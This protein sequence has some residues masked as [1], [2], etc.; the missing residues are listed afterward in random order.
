MPQAF[1]N[2]YRKIARAGEELAR[3]EREIGEFI[4]DDCYK[5]AVE[6]DPQHPGYE[7][8]KAKLIRFMAPCISELATSV[9]VSLR[10]ALDEAIGVV[11]AACGLVDSGSERFLFADSAEGFE[12]SIEAHA[13]QL[14]VEIRA[15]LCGFQPY[16]G[17]NDL[18]FALNVL[19]DAG[20][21]A[22]LAAI[23]TVLLRPYTRFVISGYLGIEIPEH[24]VWNRTEDEMVF[25]RAP[26]D[27][28]LDYEIDFGLYV[29]LD[30]IDPFDIGPL[31]GQP[32]LR[33]LEAC[34]AET[35]RVVTRI[36]VEARRLGIVQ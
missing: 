36:E 5:I 8:H 3:L 16:K 30:K 10:G 1:H 15:L 26:A 17:G 7:L 13:E 33:V 29:A 21:R 32:V 24:P 4:E 14:P 12:E 11:A 22:P 20:E 6:A 2:A 9:A 23:G 27:A 19:C 28:K 35:H 18:L 31:G 34:G 25:L